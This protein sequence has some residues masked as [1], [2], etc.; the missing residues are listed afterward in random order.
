M[1]AGAAIRLPANPD[2]ATGTPNPAH[3][4]LTSKKPSQATLATVA[5]DGAASASGF[6]SNWSS[7]TRYGEASRPPARPKSSPITLT[8]QPTDG[9]SIRGSILAAGATKKLPHRIDQTTVSRNARPEA[10]P[11]QN[12]RP[13]GFRITLTRRPASRTQ[14]GEASRPPARPKSSPITLTRRRAP[15]TQDGEAF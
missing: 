2:H 4:R 10:S 11:S 14:D 9:T 8:R 5:L 6:S 13:K 12:G 15:G 7:D 3:D 1:A